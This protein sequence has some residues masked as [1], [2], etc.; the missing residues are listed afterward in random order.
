MVVAGPYLQDMPALASAD[1][2]EIRA[3][4]TR[5][6]LDRFIQVPFE[7]HRNDAAWVPPLFSERR[8]ALDASS[9]YFRYAAAAFWIARRHG[10]DIGRISAQIDRRAEPETGSFGL[11]SA[12]DDAWLFAKLLGA[13]EAW[14]AA[15]GARRITGPL[16]LS[17]NQEAGLLVQG[18]ETPPM[19]MM[20][21]DPPWIAGHLEALGYRKAKDLYAY[22]GD[23][24]LEQ[25]PAVSKLILR[26]AQTGV[27][28]RPLRLNSYYD[29]IATLTDIF[30]DA[31][32]QNWGFL[33]LARDEAENMARQMRPLVR[34]R[35]V[36]FAEVQGRPAGFMV[37]L[38][39]VNEAIRDLS[40]RLW[41]VGW[42]YLLWRLKIAGVRSARV[43]LM[44]VRRHYANSFLGGAIAFM[45]IDAVRRECLALGMRKI[46][47]SWILEDNAAIIRIIEAVGG[48]RYKTY[49]LYQKLL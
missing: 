19:V 49:R 10:R 46:E 24:A 11:L 17:I 12:V 36:W 16:N 35:L 43:P 7:V 37:C 38:P 6:D 3:V 25:P 39:N 15:R 42:A 41:P 9:P 1:D 45:L 2:V 48:R 31:W 18:F 27:T 32:E 20:P 22:A 26:A 4:A 40:G 44:G 30:N 29:E 14:L 13:A 5:D 34:D 28:I 21:H 47:T 23:A 33:P 8:K